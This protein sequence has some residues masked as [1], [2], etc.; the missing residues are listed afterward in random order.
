MLKHS[1][2]TIQLNFV[3]H[4]SERSVKH[5]H[6]HTHSKSKPRTLFPYVR[7]EPG[8][9]QPLRILFADNLHIHVCMQNCGIVS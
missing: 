4:N 5:T 9:A 2:V 3:T 1:N 8:G 6:T 7:R